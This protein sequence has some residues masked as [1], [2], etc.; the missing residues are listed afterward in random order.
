MLL[1]L[2]FVLAC[3][4]NVCSSQNLECPRD[5][6]EFKGT[7]SCYKFQR[8]PLMNVND[9]KIRCGVSCKNFELLETYSL[10]I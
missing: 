4:L 2:A 7:V 6:V 8:Y 10:L 1:R 9:A 3:V 5:W